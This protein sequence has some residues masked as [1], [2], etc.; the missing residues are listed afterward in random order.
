[1]ASVMI[2]N[3]IFVIGGEGNPAPNSNGVF[4]QNEGYDTATDTWKEYA[5][6]DVP[7]VS[8][9][10]DLPPCPFSTSKFIS[11]RFASYPTVQMNR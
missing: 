1:M 3:S 11:R 9:G 2:N 7:R 4:S 8:W 5:P 10:V 6:M